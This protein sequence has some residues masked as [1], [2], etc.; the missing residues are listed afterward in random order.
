[1]DGMKA[2]TVQQPFAGLIASGRKTVESRRS[3][4]NHR[5]PLAICA[6]VRAWSDA[7]IAEMGDGPRGV[8]LCEVD[9]MGCRPAT[10]A[11][12]EAACCGADKLTSLDGWFAWELSAPR[13]V[14]R[15][16]VRGMP[17]IFTLPYQ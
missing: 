9:V 4:T 17:G 16:P 3:R 14:P 7:A 12:R 15:V 13:A 2:L 1:M 5:G 10:E 8:A 6:G 11:D